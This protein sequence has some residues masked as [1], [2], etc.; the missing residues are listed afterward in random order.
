MTDTDNAPIAL[1]QPDVS[2]PLPLIRIERPSADRGAKR[3]RDILDAP[4]CIFCGVPTAKDERNIAADKFGLLVHENICKDH[5]EH[6]E[7]WRRGRN[8]RAGHQRKCCECG[9][10]TT[11]YHGRRICWDCDSEVDNGLDTWEDR[12]L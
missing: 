11:M 1:E 8:A 12:C 10:V 5:S 7:S 2:R 9:R 6:P 3:E 4:R